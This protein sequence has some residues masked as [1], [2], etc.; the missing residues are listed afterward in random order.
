MAAVVHWF[1]RD[2]RV[3]DNTG[4]HAAAAEGES[5]VG[6]F[7]IDTRWWR[8]KE[9]KLGA[10]QAKFWLESLRELKG[11][12]EKLNIP[13][14]VRQDRDPVKVVLAVAR[15]VGATLITLNKEY[16]PAQIAMDERLETA[17]AGVEVRR[18]KD[19]VRY[20]EREVLT[21]AGTVYSV[22]TPYKR[23]Y[24]KRGELERGGMEPRGLPRKSARK[25]KVMSEQLPGLAELGF[26]DVELDIQAGEAAG[27]K[28]LAKFCSGEGMRNYRELRDYPAEGLA[29]R[30]GSRLSAHLNAGT[31]SIRQAF[32]AAMEKRG[33]ASVECFVGELVW[34]EF[35]RMVLCNFPRTVNEPFQTKFGHVKWADDPRMI[36]AWSEGRTGYPIVDAAMRQIRQ[37]GFM[38]NRLRMIAAM[39]L[40][41]DLDCSWVI[42]ER[43]FRK[44][45]MDYDQASNVGGWQWSASTGT[46]AAPYFRVMNP[47]LQGQ[48]FDAAGV[49]VK[50]FVPE[51]ARVPAK[52]VHCPWEMSLEMQQ[53]AGCVVGR[54]YPERVV[55]HGKAKE[56]AIRKFKR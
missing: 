36:A 1:R 51:L 21:G 43:L 2:F 8:A 26:E 18:Y 6:V 38:H 32:A 37:T 9:G 42:G 31:V 46:D 20:E 17:A 4:L 41:K 22:F 40:T 16:E 39:F 33:G 3:R 47:V 35:Y 23:A 54:D 14:V 28:L 55:E 24:L 34:R 27:A 50:R 49:F 53:E 12:L 29:G 56:F 45:L 10:H 13:L 5:V 11:A 15:E 44:W 30:G 25:M 48:R 52:Y 19:A 7:V